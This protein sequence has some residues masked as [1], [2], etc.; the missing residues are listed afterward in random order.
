MRVRN[1]VIAICVLLSLAACDD[2]ARY[3]RKLE[4]GKEYAGQSPITESKQIGFSYV[5]ESDE[6]RRLD[7]QLGIAAYLEPYSLE[8]ERILAL[9]PFVH[10]LVDGT[11]QPPGHRESS[12]RSTSSNM[13]R[14]QARE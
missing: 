13:P 7:E 3:R 2:T 9:I 14:P 4:K 5:T 1:I 6:L 12:T 10:D 11:A 8:V